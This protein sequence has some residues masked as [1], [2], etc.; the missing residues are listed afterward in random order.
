MWTHQA[1]KRPRHLSPALP[2]SGSRCQIRAAIGG[3]SCWQRLMLFDVPVAVPCAEPQPTHV[4][5]ISGR[6]AERQAL[7]ES[8]ATPPTTKSPSIISS[9]R[10]HRL[11][12]Q[13]ALRA[14]ALTN[15][16]HS[17]GHQFLRPAQFLAILPA[18]PRN[19]SALWYLVIPSQ[20]CCD[21]RLSLQTQRCRPW[22]P[23][24][25]H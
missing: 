13:S 8:S 3:L 12:R 1:C 10:P 5:Q 18:R 6:E 19:S 16:C 22:R 9:A 2:F 25:N 11:L 4:G 24:C 15:V 17:T 14:T 23:P 21:H 7:I 20:L